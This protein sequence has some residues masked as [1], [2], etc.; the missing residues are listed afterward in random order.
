MKNMKKIKKQT[1]VSRDRLIETIRQECG[2]SAQ[3]STELLRDTLDIIG[4]IF[5][6]GHNLK[7]RNFGTFNLRDKKQRVGR[8]PK[9][10]QPAIINARRVVLFKVSTIL[11]DA[12]NT[13][14]RY[15]SD[16]NR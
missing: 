15:S 2:L 13:S 12:I 4:E 6:S 9:N 5:K 14:L 7:V 3:Q 1:S 8:N 10:L 16:N 11:K